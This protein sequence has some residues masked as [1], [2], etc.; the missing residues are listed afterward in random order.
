VS[1]YERRCSGGSCGPATSVVRT[2]AF[3]KSPLQSGSYNS[4]CPLRSVDSDGSR[5][6][7]WSPKTCTISVGSA[8]FLLLPGAPAPSG[9][10][11]RYRA[12]YGR[13]MRLLCSL[14]AEQVRFYPQTRTMW[15]VSSLQRPWGFLWRLSADVADTSLSVGQMNTLHQASNFDHFFFPG[16]A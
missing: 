13:R 16:L 4:T 12:T 10:H 7:I 1:K 5:D 14:E 3:R 15:T 2:P 6:R 11:P 9:T 8:F